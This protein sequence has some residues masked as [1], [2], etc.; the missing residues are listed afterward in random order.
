M[1][2]SSILDRVRRNAFPIHTHEL[3]KFIPLTSIF[4]MIS[5]NY[6]LLRSVKDVYVIKYAG[7]EAIYYLKLFG[8]TPSI[9][10]LTLLYNRISKIVDRDRKFQIVMG[11]FFVFFGLAY[12]L[13]P[14]LKVVQLD[15]L[16]NSLNTS[17][18]RLKGLWEPIRYWPASLFYINAEAW[19]TMALGV[20]FWTFVNE[21]T[22]V[23]QSKRFYSFLSLGSSVGLIVAGLLLKSLQDHLTVIIGLIVGIVGTIS[24]TYH[25][26]AYNIQQDPEA[27]QIAVKAKKKKEKLAEEAEKIKAEL[28]ALKEKKKSLDKKEKTQKKAIKKT[29]AKPKEKPT[30]KKTPLT[31]VS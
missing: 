11:Y 31:P 14:Y 18:P 1:S 3:K 29:P 12:F 5:L 15:R 7:V 2:N 27:Y 19:G 4:F 6:S 17:F 9:L 21:I 8:V 20:L 28:D 26:F 22:S 13:M 30:K 24:I 23:E 10:A 16:A 25:R